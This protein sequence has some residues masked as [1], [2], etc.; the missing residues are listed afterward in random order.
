MSEAIISR[1]EIVG[2][3]KCMHFDVCK[4]TD[5]YIDAVSII[6]NEACGFDDIVDVW[7]R[8]KYFHKKE[9]T[10]RGLK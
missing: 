1:E 8:C 4:H 10:A 2:C 5:E 9:A 6:G 3:D 7:I